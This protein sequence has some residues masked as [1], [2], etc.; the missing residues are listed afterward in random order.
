M[1][2]ERFSSP[3]SVEHF[4]EALDPEKRQQIEQKIGDQA[5]KREAAARE[6][7]SEAKYWGV[8]Y[9]DTEQQFAQY[10]NQL[11][12]IEVGSEAYR[13]SL[14]KYEDDIAFDWRKLDHA[15][16]RAQSHNLLRSPYDLAD[17]QNLGAVEPHETVEAATGIFYDERVNALRDQI[18]TA[19]PTPETEAEKE[20]L[21]R[22][23]SKVNNYI[24]ANR[25]Y[26]LLRES[27]DSYHN[28]RRHCHNEMIKQLNAINLLAEKYGTKRFTARNFMT[29][30][31][32]YQ[33]SRDRTGML[34]LRA[35]YD[36]E[37]VLAYFRTAFR[38]N[39]ELE[40]SKTKR[41]PGLF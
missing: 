22:T 26:D 39:F 13:Q 32:K 18:A 30:D 19:A 4:D 21:R 15:T 2:S 10:H 14:A 20:L 11:P 9:N 31:F 5:T 36:R 23:W 17:V 35:N 34:N 27:Y 40:E 38:R 25:D 16:S 37:T 6:F 12:A 3:K 7:T 33:Q 24:N 29:N 8:A 41:E 1:K 28:T